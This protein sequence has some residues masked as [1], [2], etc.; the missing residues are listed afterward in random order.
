M[1][2]TDTPTST[3]LPVRSKWLAELRFVG[4][5]ALCVFSLHSVVGQPFYIPSESMM[6]GLMTGDRLIV[7]KYP[8]GWSYASPSLHLLP[9][10]R[11]RLLGRLPAR[12]DVVILTPPGAERRGEDLIKRVI[13]LPGDSV[14]MVAGRLWLNG[15]PVAV[16]DEGLRT[17]PIDG[18]FSCAGYVVNGACRLRMIRETLPEGAS[19]LTIDLGQSRLDDTAGYIV[20]E[21]HIFLMGDNRDNSADSRVPIDE[22]GL[23]GAIPLENIGGRAEFITFS[24]SGNA[25]WNPLSWPGAFRTARSGARLHE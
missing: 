19:Y 4:L 20:P 1:T 22:G 11:G 25:G 24:L 5:L 23:G 13:G 9:F 14:R 2:G 15:H 7:S 3:P 21:D 18:N 6:P 17:I 8:Y 12:G 10:M 16:R